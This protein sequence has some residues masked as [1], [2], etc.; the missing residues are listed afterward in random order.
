[1]LGIA[2]SEHS[3]STMHPANLP[4]TVENAAERNMSQLSEALPTQVELQGTRAPLRQTVDL[5]A[6]LHMYPAQGVQDVST[7]QAS[8]QFFAYILANAN[9][10]NLP[11]SPGGEYFCRCPYVHPTSDHSANTVP[12]ARPHFNAAVPAKPSAPTAS[13]DAGLELPDEL[14]L[15]GALKEDSYQEWLCLPD[16]FF[17]GFEPVVPGLQISG[18]NVFLPWSDIETYFTSSQQDDLPFGHEH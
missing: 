12:L 16:E 2:F 17:D 8:G 15:T 5:P 9:Q 4:S 14:L 7:D 13:H 10:H 1:M 18:Y 11:T 6:D 3:S